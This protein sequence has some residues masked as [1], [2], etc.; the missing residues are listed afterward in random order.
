MSHFCTSSFSAMIKDVEMK[1][2]KEAGSTR[3]RL[4]VIRLQIIL[5]AKAYR[6]GRR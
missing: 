6:R 2:T 3:G 1:T 4:S 5:E